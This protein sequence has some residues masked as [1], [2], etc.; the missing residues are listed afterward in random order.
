MIADGFELSS[1]SKMLLSVSWLYRHY[2]I[3]LHNQKAQLQII[4][5][6]QFSTANQI[7]EHSPR[8]FFERLMTL[9]LIKAVFL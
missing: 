6:L 9:L 3:A 4:T 8:T 2:I 7:A 5:V 1:L